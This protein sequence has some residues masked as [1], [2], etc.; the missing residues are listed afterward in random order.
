MRY[1]VPF[2]KS[3]V[4]HNLGLNPGLP[5]HW[6]TLLPL[7][8]WAV[9]ISK[10][11][12]WQFPIWNEKWKGMLLTLV[13]NQNKLERTCIS[14]VDSSFMFKVRRKPLEIQQCVLLS[15]LLLWCLQKKDTGKHRKVDRNIYIYIY[16][17]KQQKQDTSELG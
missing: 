10:A 5:D 1:Q 9:L 8:K 7:G 16:I 4:W 6:Q 17:F 13:T 3:L 2:L 14:K 12:I 11:L 15:N